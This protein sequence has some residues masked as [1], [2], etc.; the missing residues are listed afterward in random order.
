VECVADVH[1]LSNLSPS[2][3]TSSALCPVL[4][5]VPSSSIRSTPASGQ[6]R[7]CRPLYCTK[8]SA[9]I[10]SSA[11]RDA[12]GTPEAPILSKHSYSCISG[13]SRLP[14]EY[15]VRYT[16]KVTG[17]IVVWFSLSESVGRPNSATTDGLYWKK[18]KCTSLSLLKVKLFRQK[19]KRKSK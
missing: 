14:S 19:H 7:T 6:Q 11:H 18:Y 9:F 2:Q 4:Y 17:S 15:R 1:V 12:C 13:I 16:R 10:Q 5:I 8:A 3:L